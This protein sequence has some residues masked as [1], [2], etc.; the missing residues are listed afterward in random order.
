MVLEIEGLIATL[1]FSRIPHLCP[2]S[3]ILFFSL[4]YSPIATKALLL[5]TSVLATDIPQEL[6]G[7]CF[8]LNE[9]FKISSIWRNYQRYEEIQSKKWKMKNNISF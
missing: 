9:V 3:H 1:V 5:H 2:Y 7:T 4:T 8:W 6:L